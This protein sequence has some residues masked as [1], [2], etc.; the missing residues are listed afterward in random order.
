MILNKVRGRG[1]F[2]NWIIGRPEMG[3]KGLGV[4]G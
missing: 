2:I 3:K 1:E 4:R